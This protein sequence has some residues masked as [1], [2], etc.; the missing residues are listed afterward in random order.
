[1]RFS[2]LQIE[3]FKAI[4]SA[5]LELGPGL[6]V[7]YG[8]NDLGKSTLGVALRAALLLPSTS[9]VASE[10]VPWQQ[11]V[12]PVV[13]LTFLTDEAKHWR[14]VK[15]FTEN[16]ATLSFSKDGKEFSVDSHERAVDEKLRKLLGWGITSP[17]GRGGP[18]GMP[19][20]FIANAL[21]AAQTD[22]E[23]ILRDGL[24]KDPDTGG[25][26][27]LTEA[28]SA[29]AQDPLVRHVL[30]AAQKEHE[31]HFTVTGR[32]KSG[33]NAPLTQASEAVKK[34]TD[35]LVSLQHTLSQS[36]ALEEDA[37][38]LHDLWLDAQQKVEV[39]EQSLKRAQA[40]LKRSSEKQVAEQK[41]AAEQQA[42][43]QVDVLA[44]RVQVLEAD[45]AANA[46][47]VKT[48]E[49]ALQSAQ[50]AAKAAAL[51]VREAE[52]VHRKASSADGEAERAVARATLKEELAK[53]S[54]S[55]AEL[56]SRLEKAKAAARVAD[57]L[58]KL[59]DTRK[60]LNEQL[61]PART[62]LA[63]ATEEAA[64]AGALMNYGQW[65]T[66][67][68]VAQSAEKWRSEAKTVRADA[69]SK[70]TTALKVQQN[71]KTLEDEIAARRETLPDDKA[72][73]A[74]AKLRRDI[75]LAEAALGGGVTVVVKPRSPLL[76]RSTADENS[77]EEKKV[78]KEL[79]IEA[80]RRVQ[81]SIGDL[82]DIEV[83]TGAAEK[84]KD[85][86]HLRK[87]WK[88]DA[89]PAFE[90]AG[91]RTLSEL[92]EVFTELSEQLE[93]VKTLRAT[94]LQSEREAETLRDRAK[95]LD[96]KA[97]GT[98]STEQLDEK[99]AAIGYPLEALEKLFAGLGS[100][101][102]SQ[103]RPLNELKSAAL[104]QAS[105]LSASL[106][107]DLKLTDARLADLSEKAPG[108]PED[109]T[110]LEQSLA[111]LESSLQKGAEKL[112]QLEQEGTGAKKQAEAKLEQAQQQLAQLETAVNVASDALNAARA[113]QSARQGE[114]DGTAA[115]L[116]AAHREAVA[117]RVEA[118]KKQLATFA[119][120]E[121][122]TAEQFTARERSVE[123]T[124][125]TAEQAR[126][127]FANAE[128][129]LSKV[130]GPQAR[131]QVR[132]LEEA[133]LV[134]KAREQL[135]EVDAAAW[136]MLVEAV[137]EAEKEDSSS[138]GSALAVPVTQRFAE[139]TKGRYPS[140]KFD[141]ALQLSGIEGT[142]S[143]KDELLN[144]LSVGTRD[145]LATLVRL[146]IALQLQ[147]T[148]VLDDHL[149]H[150]DVTR[151]A[152]FREALANTAAKT[153]VVVLTCRPL[154]YVSEAAL[155]I[156]GAMKDAEGTR[157]IDLAKVI[158]RR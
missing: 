112:A 68:E 126:H 18:R 51:A 22:V 47:E 77:V 67:S 76:L 65:R 124:R 105:K 12:S 110:K 16:D 92:D 2:K 35:E 55:R 63:E 155:P 30:D 78:A 127:D 97:A 86:E 116:K 27:K 1:M 13:T 90:R 7:L 149:V 141:A 15:R 34:L 142:Q 107:G 157:V 26:L 33:L 64:M 115:Q 89:L 134:A 93:R 83:V 53:H 79:S 129:A 95:M 140:V 125:V 123:L 74:L 146:A 52:E 113:T 39:A 128:G 40:G 102:E 145:H 73:G 101:W 36:V 147:S 56:T 104:T 91:V 38:R 81:L 108:T 37:K 66:A 75:D 133:V 121:V 151:L 41:L 62:Q 139:L 32:R 31:Q 109:V 23:G 153:Q 72:R 98:P 14:V 8:P 132:Q 103:A 43:A 80:D 84:R 111:A 9:S 3:N 158:K 10:Y 48:Q 114:R 45:I 59:N 137:R 130:G 11:P 122:L 28:L 131:E 24:V 29:L 61:G 44:A 70:S 88:T 154:D 17:G 19:E 82:V 4:V 94:A 20:S 49:A 71:A 148:I 46:L 99:R 85:A 25:K 106:E 69:L 57:E 120:V 100:Q 144:V 119:D 60:K 21:L 42:L 138:L 143:E 6:N 50:Q 5:E 150:S 118:A 54:V 117:A 156:A 136:R 152:W 58:K 135:I 87:K 96:E